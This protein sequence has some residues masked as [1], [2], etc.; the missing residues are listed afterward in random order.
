MVQL[1]E[2]NITLEDILDLDNMQ[3]ITN[4]DIKEN[5]FSYKL[6]QMLMPKF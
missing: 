5:I 1:A 3:Y 6:A 4:N 2:R